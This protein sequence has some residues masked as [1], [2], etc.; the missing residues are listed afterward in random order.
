MNAVL[1]MLSLRLRKVP[2]GEMDS[3][4]LDTQV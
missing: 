2:Q 3:A 1:D 4:Q